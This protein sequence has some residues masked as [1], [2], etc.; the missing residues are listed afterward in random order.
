MENIIYQIVGNY[1]ITISEIEL[2]SN[3]DKELIL[4]NFSGVQSSKV[5]Q[6]S[7]VELFESIVKK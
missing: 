2:I 6:H 4:K 3:F 5:S 7:I 1:H